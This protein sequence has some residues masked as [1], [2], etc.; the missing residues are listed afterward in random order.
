MVAAITLFSSI[1]SLARQLYGNLQG[2]EA[3]GLYAAIATPSVLIQAASRY[4]YAPFLV[5]LANKWNQQEHKAFFGMYIK[6]FLLI[7]AAGLASVL[8]I[9]W[10][11]PKNSIHTLWTKHRTARMASSWR[12]VSNCD[13][14]SH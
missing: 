1:A 4:L 9:E 10:V 2:T 8:A 6:V 14:S 5:P 12:N 3:L 7:C 13:D 11:G